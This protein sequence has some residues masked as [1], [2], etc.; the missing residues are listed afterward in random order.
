MIVR[1]ALPDIAHPDV[2]TVLITRSA[3]AEVYADLERG[4]WPKELISCTTFVS[5]DGEKNVT[6]TQWRNGEA[7]REYLTGFADIEA[8]EYR[9]YRSNAGVNPPVPGCIVI[10][11][12]EFD[13]PDHD[14]QRRWVDTV[15]DAMAGETDPHPGGIAGHF[16]VS[17]D[18]TRVLPYAEWTNADAHRDA[19]ERSGRG[20][21]GSGSGWQRVKEFPGVIDS[22]F[23]RYHLL[24]SLSESS[25]PEPDDVLDSPTDWVADHIRDYVETDGQSGH[26]Y[27]GRPSLLLTTRGRK[28]GKLRRTALIY[29]QDD[30]RYILVASNAG[31]PTHPAWYLNLIADPDVTIQVGAEKFTGR[32]RP[33]TA[34]EKPPLWHLM[35]AIFP[36]YDTYQAKSHREIPLVIVE[37]R[38]EESSPPGGRR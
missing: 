2:D 21:I 11:D 27:Q 5:T 35:T 13:G 12:V 22:G 14:R 10:L 26:L 37:R 17:T 33:A 3:S 9:L 19:I 20:M 4:P 18:G 28:S 24:H 16:H 32:A 15:F 34:E 8:V 30:D 6:Y 31:S 25:A 36:L 7:G 1:N 29:G 38:T 23:T